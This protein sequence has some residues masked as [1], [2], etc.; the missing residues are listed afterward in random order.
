MPLPK[1]GGEWC[2]GLQWAKPC[3]QLEGGDP[4]PLPST[5]EAMPAAL[6][7]AL[8]PPAPQRQGHTG[9]SPQCPSPTPLLPVG[10]R[11]P[12]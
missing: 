11:I 3:Q 8:G 1:G 4:S 2:P 9:E 5:G 12:C 6:C 10:L 7:P